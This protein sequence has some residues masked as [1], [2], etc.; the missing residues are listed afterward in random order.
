[1]KKNYRK[2]KLTREK[3]CEDR[4]TPKEERGHFKKCR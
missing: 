3:L 4:K 2:E 1:M